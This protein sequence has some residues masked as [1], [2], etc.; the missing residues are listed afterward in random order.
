MQNKISKGNCLI[1]FSF[2]EEI[3]CFYLVFDI[4]V[5]EFSNIDGKD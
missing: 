3:R 4:V 5:N 1:S 2:P